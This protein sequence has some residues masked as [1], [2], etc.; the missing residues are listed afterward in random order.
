[1]KAWVIDRFGG[2]EV[3]RL[4]DVP[5]PE[6]GEGEV[7]V[8]VDGASVNPVDPKITA[9]K[10]P[11]ASPT[12]F[13]AGVLRDF[14]GVIVKRGPGVT[15]RTVGEAVYGITEV[16]AAAEYT[17]AKIDA[18]G[19]M[20][21]TLDPAEAAVTPLAAMTAWQA[22]FDHGHLERGQRVLI[23]AA[24]GGVGTFAVQF[25]KWADAYVIGTAS[26]KNH[27]LLR[28]LGADELIDHHSQRFEEIARNVDLVLHAIGPEHLP[29]SMSV[30]KRG[31][32]LI[33]ILAEPD[34][35][36]A[37]RLGIRAERFMMRP[38]TRELGKIALLIDDGQ[39]RPVIE[40]MVDF[41]H[42]VQ[43]IVEVSEGH[44]VG[45][46]GI[47]IRTTADVSD[48]GQKRDEGYLA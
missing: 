5:I 42:V 41:D 10:F 47:R 37:K 40:K 11:P 16:G 34:Q 7:L 46:I 3:Y 32:A 30:L 24:S 38:D 23:H 25:A 12:C 39:V 13:P 44:A 1:M 45:K 43:A 48:P 2:P 31:G 26:A 4:A 19:P 36:E 22:L 28:S 14:S 29:G 21:A 27:G 9:G 35:E 17:V 15:E 18:I 33:S 20:P 8:R 6:P